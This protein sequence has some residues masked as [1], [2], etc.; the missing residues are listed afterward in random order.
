M[1]YKTSESQIQLQL[2]SLF[3]RPKIPWWIKI[4]TNQSS[5]IFFFCPFDNFKFAKRSQDG[6]IEDLVT[7][8]AFGITIE[9]AQCQPYLLTIFDESSLPY[10]S[11]HLD[12]VY[13]LGSTIKQADSQLNF[14]NAS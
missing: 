4:K 6:Y 2:S 7:G 10:C 3:N 12:S 8:N 1:S 5:C 13:Q 9:I 14:C 11:D